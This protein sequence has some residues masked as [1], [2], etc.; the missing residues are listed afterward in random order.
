VRVAAVRAAAVRAAAA[1]AAAAARGGGG[2]GGGGLGGGG[3]G[4]GLG[5]GDDW[6]TTSWLLG[7][8]RATGSSA[9]R[10]AWNTVPSSTCFIA[11]ISSLETLGK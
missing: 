5:G 8:A 11:R 2:D 3:L 1:R 9:T 6:R 4:G 7:F 10:I